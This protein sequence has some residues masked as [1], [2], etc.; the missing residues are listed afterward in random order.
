M[1]YAA[2][3]KDNIFIFIFSCE[4]TTKQTV[5]FVWIEKETFIASTHIT[6]DYIT[7]AFG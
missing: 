1:A 4:G 6:K 5:R 7:P 2:R 3:V